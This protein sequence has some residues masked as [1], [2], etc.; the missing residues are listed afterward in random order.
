MLGLKEMI[1][2]EKNTSEHSYTLYVND[3]NSSVKLGRYGDLK[4][5]YD[6]AVKLAA[7]IDNIDVIFYFENAAGNVLW[8]SDGEVD[9]DVSE[10]MK[11][12]EKLKKDVY[13]VVGVFMNQ[14]NTYDSSI[15]KT[16]ESCFDDYEEDM[17]R[18][19]KKKQQNK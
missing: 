10:E 19:N 3:E 9:I 6:L 17:R 13:E 12:Y 14:M 7:N 15:Y 8:S 4:E 2:Y 18:Y 5:V 11:Y 16:L 1:E